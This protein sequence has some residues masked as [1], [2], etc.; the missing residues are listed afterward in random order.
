MVYDLPFCSDVAYAVPSNPSLDIPDLIKIYDTNAASLFKN[1]TYSLQQIPCNASGESLYSLARNCTQCEKAY[2]EWLCAVTIPRCHDFTSTRDH[3]WERNLGQAFLNG[4][5]LP[6]NY[7]GRHDVRNMS[8]RNPII[9]SE[10]KPGPYKEVL[11]C[12]DLCHELVRSCPTALG[13]KCPKKPWLH[14]SYGERGGNDITCSYFGAAYYMN[15]ARGLYG[16][17]FN[18]LGAVGFWS[19]IWGLGF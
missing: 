11:P 18:F 13:F 8:S 5:M 2:K 3:L 12:Q 7:K 14:D 17:G 6:D 9:D 4:S 10:I 16:F 19:L 15:G 1:F